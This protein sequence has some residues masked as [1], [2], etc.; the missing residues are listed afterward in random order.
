MDINDE[1]NASLDQLKVEV[2]KNKYYIKL[3]LPSSPELESSIL[4]PII[5]K[6]SINNI[7]GDVIVGWKTRLFSTNIKDNDKNYK[8]LSYKDANK[9]EDYTKKYNDAHYIHRG[10]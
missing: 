3:K 8:E 7:N 4:T 2:N 6:F 5:K 9:K 10:I 1:K